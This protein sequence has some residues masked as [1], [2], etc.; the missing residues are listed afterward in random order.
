M[1]HCHCKYYRHGEGIFNFEHRRFWR[2]AGN[3][4]SPTPELASAD[5]HSFSLL[6]PTPPRA[7]SNHY[8]TAYRN[9]SKS[10]SGRRELQVTPHRPDH[11]LRGSSSIRRYSS[12]QRGSVLQAERSAQRLGRLRRTRRAKDCIRLRCCTPAFGRPRHCMR[13][14]GC[15]V[16]LIALRRS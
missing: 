14:P 16:S 10:L 5:S 9:A 8:P 2:R 12:N 1:P 7:S 6:S 4:D 11:S 15:L 13:R 3:L